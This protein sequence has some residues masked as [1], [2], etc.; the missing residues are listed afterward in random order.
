MGIGMEIEVHQQLLPSGQRVVWCA[1]L[2][3]KHEDGLA[4]WVGNGFCKGENNGNGFYLTVYLLRT[5][6]LC[7]GMTRYE[8]EHNL[9]KYWC[10]KE[11]ETSKSPSE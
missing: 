5:R 3:W 8:A 7:V 2:R 11:C 9:L 1:P 6:M 4:W 10:H